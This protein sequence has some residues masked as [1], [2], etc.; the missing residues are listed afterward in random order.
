MST[1]DQY[2]VE[3]LARER[4]RSTIDLVRGVL[5]RRKDWRGRDYYLHDLDVMDLLPPE[6]SDAERNA[7]LLH[8]A[9]EMGVMSLD[10][11]PR[12]GFDP[13]V[14]EIVK[15]ITNGPA[16]KGHGAYVEKCRT[17]VASGNRGAMRV[18]LA[19][20]LANEGHPTN[21]YADTIAIM[22]AGL[23]T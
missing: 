10:S 15:L 2:I 12:L 9:V 17:I 20:M 1:D 19:D 23:E 5:R 4:L 22:R 18:K 21:D 13:E 7:A 8:S 3:S 11:L 14:V 6:A 16:V